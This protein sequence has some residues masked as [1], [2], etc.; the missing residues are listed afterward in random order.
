M[1]KVPE[2]TAKNE[3]NAQGFVGARLTEARKARGISATDLADMVGR[4][5]AVDLQV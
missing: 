2:R 5:R 4:K 3:H 1:M